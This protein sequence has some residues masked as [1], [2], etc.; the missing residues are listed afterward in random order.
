MWLGIA[1]N[2]NAC[3]SLGGTQPILRGRS[4]NHPTART[5]ILLLASLPNHLVRY[6]TLLQLPPVKTRV[7]TTPTL[8][9]PKFTVGRRSPWTPSPLVVEN[10]T[11]PLPLREATTSKSPTKS[12]F[13]TTPRMFWRSATPRTLLPRRT[14]LLRPPHLQPPLPPGLKPFLAALATR[15]PAGKSLLTNAVPSGIYYYC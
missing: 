5:R 12:K 9:G 11:P 2:V 3:P 14:S 7:Q 1:R 4:L 15:P 10:G 13:A 6:P 8:S